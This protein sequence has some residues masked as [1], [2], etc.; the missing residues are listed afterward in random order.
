MNKIRTNPSE[1]LMATRFGGDLLLLDSLLE[2]PILGKRIRDINSALSRNT[3]RTKL[4]GSAVRVDSKLL[5]KISDTFNRVRMRSGITKKMEAYVYQDSSINAFVT[6][7]RTHLFVVLSSGAVNNL[8]EEELQFVIGHELGHAIFKHVDIASAPLLENEQLSPKCSMKL[9]AWKRAAEISADRVGL[10]CCGSLSVAAT[11]LFKSLSG[12]KLKGV[13][14]EP[15]EFE[16]QWDVLAE[17]VIDGG[18]N[19]FWHLTHPFPPLRIKAMHQFLDSIPLEVIYTSSHKEISKALE[20]ADKKVSKLLSLMDPISRGINNDADPFLARFILWGGAY[21]SLS[22]GTID[23]REISKIL[24][25]T[26]EKE[27]LDILKEGSTGMAKCLGEFCACLNRRNKKLTAVETHRILEG[28]LHIAYSDGIMDGLEKKAF[29]ELAGKL[30]IA[31]DACE[32]LISNFE[33][34]R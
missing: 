29:M 9:F 22:N 32:I 8:S 16:R 18:Y 26:S 25:L 3:I 6:T 7:G 34:E 10:V 28:L 2:D 23:E 15:I 30:K 12:L 24:E 14:I 31:S 13:S 17:E 19:D 1:K 27:I 20:T 21:L 5:P 4:L 11:T 33:K